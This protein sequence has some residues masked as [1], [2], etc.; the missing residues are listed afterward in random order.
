MAVNLLE[1]VSAAASFA[2][3]QWQFSAGSVASDSRLDLQSSRPEQRMAPPRLR[4][5]Y[6]VPH[7][8][9]DSSSPTEI[10]FY[11]D[12]PGLPCRLPGSARDDPCA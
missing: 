8:E 10:D 1:T 4:R 9:H 11:Y 7:R 12:V 5:T 2:R 6:P 3:A